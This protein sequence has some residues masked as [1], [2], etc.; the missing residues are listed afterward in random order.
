MKTIWLST[1]IQSCRKAKAC[2]PSHK[3]HLHREIVLGQ[4]HGVKRSLS[5]SAQS[6][7]DSSFGCSAAFNISLCGPHGDASHGGLVFASTK[8][9]FQHIGVMH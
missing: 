4:R 9:N 5:F 3:G 2:L 8:H 7:L 1:K 6:G